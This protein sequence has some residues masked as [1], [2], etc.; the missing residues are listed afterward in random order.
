[1]KKSVI[2]L[3]AAVICVSACDVGESS[4]SKIETNATQSWTSDSTKASSSKTQTSTRTTSSSSQT[5]STKT[6]SSSASSS[7][8]ATS[9]KKTYSVISGTITMN[10]PTYAP[11]PISGNI[12]PG[13][14]ITVSAGLPI[15]YCVFSGAQSNKNPPLQGVVFHICL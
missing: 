11:G 10:F 4:Y 7:T 9:S 1:M 3:I 5:D 14:G 15:S 13:K 12:D 2:A 6:S 8:T